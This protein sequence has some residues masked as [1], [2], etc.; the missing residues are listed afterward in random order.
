MQLVGPPKNPLHMFNPQI[1][2]QPIFKDIFALCPFYYRSDKAAV[3]VVG[4]KRWPFYSGGSGLT[5][6]QNE[7]GPCIINTTSSIIVQRSTA[8][9]A[10][11]DFTYVVWASTTSVAAGRELLGGKYISGSQ[12]MRFGRSGNN[13]YIYLKSAG[14]TTSMSQAAPNHN[15][16]NVHCFICS[17]SPSSLEGYY[18]GVLLSST[19]GAG[20]DTGGLTTYLEFADNDSGESWVGALS[21]GMIW[22]RGLSAVE[23]RQ[24]Y[25]MGPS[26]TP[27]NEQ[28]PMPYRGAIGAGTSSFEAGWA[29]N[30][31]RVLL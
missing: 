18:D 22:S 21:L 8:D 1:L 10:W 6:G 12:Y 31:N 5:W 15:D 29:I 26:L 4:M 30:S 2:Q 17:S 27:I 13:F 19:A 24:I 23:C 16:G 25:E 20:S 28:F 9:L 14:G 11:N 7:Y 3:D